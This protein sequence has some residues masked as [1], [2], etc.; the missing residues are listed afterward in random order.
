VRA[1]SHVALSTPT[2]SGKSLCYNVPVVEAL[3]RWR[4]EQQ[5]QQQQQQPAAGGGH[6][7]PVALYL[8]P[9][10]ALAQDQL[11]ALQQLLGGMA[12]DTANAASAGG[13]L[14]RG[15]GVDLLGNATLRCAT[16][17]GD[18]AHAD[19]L[20]LRDSADIVLTNPDMLHATVLPGHDRGW[21]ALLGRV[22]FV[23]V[24]ECHVYRGTFGAH[25]ACVLR[26]LWR[27]CALCAPPP[28]Y[29]SGGGGGGGPGGGAGGDAE[30]AELRR[31]PLAI[32]CS[33][34]IS[35]PEQHFRRLLP[36]VALAGGASDG[37]AAAR[38]GRGLVV[39]GKGEGGAPQGRRL[40]ALWRPQLRRP[41]A[42][43]RFG[44]RALPG[45]GGMA[46][47][48]DAEAEKLAMETAATT[49][50]KDEES[51]GGESEEVATAAALGEQTRCEG[52]ATAAAMAATPPAHS[53]KRKG[54]LYAH[55]G[56]A[57]P[58]ANSGSGASAGRAQRRRKMRL[59]DLPPPTETASPIV[60][61][62]QLLAALV[63][64]EIRVVAFCR[65][66]KLVELVLLYAREELDRADAAAAAAGGGGGSGSGSGDGASTA[67]GAGAAAAGGFRRPALAQRLAAYR[68]GYTAADRRSLEARLFNGQ[69]LGV[70]ATNA[71]ELGVDIGA[72]DATIQ[73]G[74]PSS[75]SSLWQQAG[76]AG[77]GGRPALSLVVLFDS[78]LDNAVARRPERLLRAPVEAIALD[79]A[80]SLVMR[81]QL[82]CAAAEASLQ[83][84]PRP[85][86]GE[87]SGAGG[88][89]A[90]AGRWGADV[91]AQWGAGAAMG[92]DND[93]FGPGF[94]AA[95]S[96]LCDA[97]LLRRRPRGGDGCC[98]LELD[99]AAVHS[100]GLGGGP[101]PTGSGGVVDEVG[102]RAT[103]CGGTS[104]EARAARVLLDAM[105]QSATGAVL[106]GGSGVSSAVNIR[107]IHDCTFKVVDDA[108]LPTQQQQQAAAEVAAA[109]AAGGDGGAVAL[110]GED[111]GGVPAAAVIDL[112]E[113]S[114]AFFCLYEGAVYLHQGRSYLV[115]RLDLE[116]RLAHC[117]LAPPAL[118][119]YTAPR[120]HTDVRCE[121]REA[122]SRCAAV[123]FGAATVITQ[124]WGYRRLRRRSGAIISMHEF[125]LP[126]LEYG[127]RALW[128]DIDPA[129]KEA[130]DAAGEDFL[131]G[132]HAAAHA[133]LAAAPGHVLCEP[134]VDVTCEH[135]NAFQQRPKPL[136]LVLFDRWAGGVGVCR[137][138]F[139]C[140]VGALLGTALGAVRGCDCGIGCPSCVHDR[141]C[142]EFNSVIDKAAGARV[143]AAAKDRFDASEHAWQE[144]VRRRQRQRQR[145]EPHPVATAPWRAPTPTVQSV[146][147]TPQES[148]FRIQTSWI[149]S[150]PNYSEQPS[151]K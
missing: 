81:S 17:D 150:M 13:E 47:A 123:H 1:G 48:V 26:R 92:A 135:P 75:I 60:L 133:L 59:R 105:A 96:A 101:G 102:A 40:V 85:A 22:R 74:C 113:Y 131:G 142:A 112:V 2:A 88:S 71:L 51:S 93:L 21:G 99:T 58:L 3:L 84:R 94:S 73:L 121:R 54:M 30:L 68:A 67:V 120:D 126:P 53:A 82:L 6:G 127:T 95:A 32:C 7:G 35:N 145:Q 44:V 42:V 87:C 10:K 147:P 149:A 69:L 24:D 77:R 11:R 56:G 119:Y 19:R 132:V 90:P 62:A 128:I 78:A 91:D 5:Q 79:P 33:A 116:R 23:V 64:M 103:A 107:S 117:R 97:G 124:V 110:A 41:G 108:L 39:V 16:L 61:A 111:D 141:G 28:C 89:A 25:V 109:A 125:S 18:T 104:V 38:R 80:H 100:A 72:L 76:R 43:A 122:S 20:E 12:A 115:R 27:L 29:S 118:S 129:V 98:V 106:A 136:R 63:R 31:G 83:W 143:L 148:S 46:G 15:R 151:D 134:A 34:T 8:F 70:A 37:R 144:Q 140:G 52:G 65:T 57:A 137:A 114:R 146:V 86:A 4:D 130:C 55:D 9:T 36:H 14:G 139:E 45:G 50:G 138:L 49:G 66:R